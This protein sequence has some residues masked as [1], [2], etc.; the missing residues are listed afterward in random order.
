[1]A[2]A[3]RTRNEGTVAPTPTSVNPFPKNARRVV[4]SISFIGSAIP[5]FPVP[6]SLFPNPRISEGGSVFERL[7]FFAV[8]GAPVAT[9][10]WVP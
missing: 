7:A 3:A 5:L 4:S 6:R 1:M 2:Y 9:V 8:S 10:L